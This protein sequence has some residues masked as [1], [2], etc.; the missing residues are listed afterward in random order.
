MKRVW[1]EKRVIGLVEMKGRQVQT[2]SIKIFSIAQS[3]NQGHSENLEKSR[4]LI[5]TSI[6]LL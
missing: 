4:Y 6:F 5:F 3:Q 2:L 1:S